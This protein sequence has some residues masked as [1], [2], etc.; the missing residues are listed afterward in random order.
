MRKGVLYITYDGV[1]EPLGQSQVLR[2]LEILSVD[3]KVFLISF[4][5]A[6]DWKAAENQRTLI[7]N[8]KNSNIH[9]TPLRYHKHPS[10]IATAFDILQGIIIG[11]W[12]CLRYQILIVHARSYVSSVMALFLKK[13]FGLKFIFDMRGFWADERID[14]GIWLKKNKIYDVAKWF[15]RRFLLSADCVVSLTHAA[16]VEMRKFPYLQGESTR[17]EVITTCADLNLFKF[18][19]R[20]SKKEQ[21]HTAFTLG[22]VGSVGVWYLFDETLKCFKEL[23]KQIPDARL[24]ILNRGDH[25]YIYKQL[26]IFRISTDSVQIESASHEGVVKAMNNMDAGIFLIKPVYSK[27][28]SAPTKL[29]EFLG[30]GVPCLG[31]AMVGDME[32]I[33]RDEHV[34]VILNSFN[35]ISIKKA[36]TKLITL[37]HENDIKVRCRNVAL[38]HFSLTKGVKKYDEIY[39][40]LYET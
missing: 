37:T 10:A 27:L 3:H 40:E 38:H 20:I 24:H 13:I 29:G 17:F 12:I 18:K 31:N 33:L 28:A 21:K 34:G 1:L 32:A 30:C 19:E 11:T 25:D 7:P 9:W 8:I 6:D 39:Q 5:K 15:E 23:Q 14:G 2:Y 36:I 35:E 4:E 16:V 26:S 22:Y